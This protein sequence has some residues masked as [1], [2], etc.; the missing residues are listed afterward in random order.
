MTRSVKMWVSYRLAKS[1]RVIISN[2]VAVTV[3]NVGTTTVTYEW[4]K[5]QRGDYIS[6]K[7]SDFVQRFYCHYPRSIL[8]PGEQKEFIFSFKS[9]RVGMFN[10]EWELLTEPLLQ[11]ALPMVC[12]SGIATQEDALKPKRE[13]F[14]KEYEQKFSGRD[15]SSDNIDDLVKDIKDPLLVEPDLSD[16][17]IFGPIFER[18]NRHLALY[19]SQETMEGFWELYDDLVLLRDR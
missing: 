5:V 15:A 2:C 8:K 13:I 12:L 9:E 3:K 14:W 17:E 4:K 7:K 16:P 19:H 1:R 11:S 10:E 6:S 18:L